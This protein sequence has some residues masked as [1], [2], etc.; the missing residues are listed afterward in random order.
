V[1]GNFEQP[2]EFRLPFIHHDD[3]KT[4]PKNVLT[5]QISS[6]TPQQKTNNK[7]YAVATSAR[8][9]VMGVHRNS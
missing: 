6:P 2:D 9:T 5:T 8:V 3:K 7:I 1:R 4:D